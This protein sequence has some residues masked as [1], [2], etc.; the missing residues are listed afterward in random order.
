MPS[1]T[2]RSIYDLVLEVTWRSGLDPTN[3]SDRFTS[4]LA[5]MAG[6]PLPIKRISGKEVDQMG[7]RLYVKNGLIDF[8]QVNSDRA[9]KGLNQIRLGVHVDENS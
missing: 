4:A 7:L 2:K 6:N 9:G 8:D 1:L 3:D 5:K